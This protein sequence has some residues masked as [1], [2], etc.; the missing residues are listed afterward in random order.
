MA[1]AKEHRIEYK[2]GILNLD[3]QQIFVNS[4]K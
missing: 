1:F 4:K 2:P 3:T